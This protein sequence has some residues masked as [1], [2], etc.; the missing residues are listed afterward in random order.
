MMST[1][2]L[3]AV[4][5]GY[6]ARTKITPTKFGIDAVKDPNLVR[7]LKNNKR[8]PNL[9]TVDKIMNFIDGNIKTSKKIRIRT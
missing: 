5:D 2:D 8:A 4:I 7:Q 3:I 9:R 1:N 6:I